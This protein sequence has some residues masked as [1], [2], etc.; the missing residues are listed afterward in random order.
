MPTVLT[1]QNINNAVTTPYNINLSISSVV[2]ERG[3][4]TGRTPKFAAKIN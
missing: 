3:S 2:P 4:K 1:R